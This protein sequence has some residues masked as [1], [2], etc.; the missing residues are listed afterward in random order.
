MLEMVGGK[1]I[2]S[3]LLAVSFGGEGNDQDYYGAQSIFNASHK[4]IPTADMRYDNLQGLDF[5]AMARVLKEAQEKRQFEFLVINGDSLGAMFGLF[6][7]LRANI[8]VAGFIANSGPERLDDATTGAK[9]A[10]DVVTRVPSST[11]LRTTE[12]GLKDLWCYFR[13]NSL[14]SAISGLPKEVLSLPSQMG[15]GGSAYLQETQLEWAQRL[16]YTDLMPVLY[17]NGIVDK[18]FTSPVF[19]AAAHD[20][21]IRPYAAHRDWSR[22]FGRFG[23]TMPLLHMGPDSGH[24]DVF[25]E[26]APLQQSGYFDHLIRRFD[27]PAP[28]LV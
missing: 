9:L 24:A 2:K 19:L 7:A 26:V 25:A 14:D 10:A 5:K 12:L 20:N 3:N 8:P 11:L 18:N 13:D 1:E 6:A 17:R 28:V 23:M 15:N 16:D 27:T 4:R 21:V 22:E